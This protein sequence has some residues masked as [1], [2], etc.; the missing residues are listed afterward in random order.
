MENTV[1]SMRFDAGALV[2]FPLCSFSDKSIL[3]HLSPKQKSNRC[4]AA[5]YDPNASRLNASSTLPICHSINT[6]LGVNKTTEARRRHGLMVPIE[7]RGGS[8]RRQGLYLAGVVVDLRNH[9]R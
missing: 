8:S 1:S 3:Q 2:G 9:R 4:C 5:L 6:H 7:G